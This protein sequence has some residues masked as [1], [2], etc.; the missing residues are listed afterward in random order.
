LFY[1]YPKENIIGIRLQL[2]NFQHVFDRSPT[3]PIIINDVSSATEE[4]KARLDRLI[5]TK[6]ENTDIFS[7]EPSC[8]CG[9]ITGGYNLGVMCHNCRTPVQELFEQA[10]RPLVWIRS[11]VGVEALINPMVWIMLSKKFTKSGFNLIE[12]MCNTDYQPAVNRPVEVDEL[13]IIG[14]TR[15]Y[16]NFVTNFKEYINILYGLKHFKE[17]K[18]AVDQLRQLLEEQKDCIFS[19]YL[20][21]PNKALMVI[22]DTKVG[23]Y[24]DPIIIDAIDAIRT[25]GSIDSPM[26]NFTLRQKEN[27][28]AKTINMLAMKFYYNVYHSIMASKNGLFRKHVFG[29]RNHFSARTVI[30]SNTKAHKYDELEIAW[31]IGVTMLKIHLTNKLLKR[32][33]NPNQCV[34]LLQE[35]TVK[36]HPLLDELFKELIDESPEKGIVCSWNRNPSLGRGSI[37]RM[38][39]TKVKT[40][41]N[42]PTITL[43]ILCVKSFNADFDGRVCRL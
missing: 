2:V 39:I 18:G 42:D 25:I 13:L 34:A 14:V 10:L 6:Y 36:Y 17:K 38:R 3:Q 9:Q 43:S 12:W 11:P 35:Y 5:S 40:D 26:S 30:S 1:F 21:L 15:G 32:G 16:N 4:D 24:V 29:T 33:F 28:T 37:Q 7:N 23:T 41:V 8:E 31:G 27:R 22:E 19:S 20:P